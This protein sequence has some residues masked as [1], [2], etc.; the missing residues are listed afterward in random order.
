MPT[1][2]EDETDEIIRA[3][4]D[5]IE[6]HDTNAALSA[7][8]IVLLDGCVSVA[9]S[10]RSLNHIIDQVTERLTDT[11]VLNRIWAELKPEDISH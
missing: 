1:P 9:R 11:E 5:A 8:L 7:L 3:I 6:G 4:G 2:N 10:R